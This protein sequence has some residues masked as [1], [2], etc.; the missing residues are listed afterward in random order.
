MTTPASAPTSPALIRQ[1]KRGAAPPVTPVRTTKLAA[2]ATAAGKLQQVGRNSSLLGRTPMTP[3]GGIGNSPASTM[4][5]TPY[6]PNL[7]NR[8]MASSDASILATPP[9]ADA[10]PLA[11]LSMSIMSDNGFGGIGLDGSPEMKMAALLS[12]AGAMEQQKRARAP[13]EASNWR[14]RASQNGIRVSQSTDS[15]FADDE[16]RFRF[17]LWLFATGSNVPFFYLSCAAD[18]E[19][20]CVS[21]TK[22]SVRSSLDGE[23]FFHPKVI[24]VIN[25]P[26]INDVIATANIL[27]QPFL[28]THRRVRSTTTS[29]NVPAM[30]PVQSQVPEHLRTPDRRKLAPF[31][32]LNTPPPKSSVVDRIKLKGTMTE[33][34]Q[35]R[36]RAPFGPVCA[37]M[38]LMTVCR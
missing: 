27:S 16:G 3:A 7:S 33:P 9:P 18:S 17:S 29:Q 30:A 12:G 25:E 26:L 21:P 4:T 2:P 8:S 20:H 23:Y 15:Q 22:S 19:P 28:S 1:S 6:T 38:L 37:F 10:P 13:S 5:S 34:A 11:A 14:S 32:A 24:F 31:N 35:P 36:R